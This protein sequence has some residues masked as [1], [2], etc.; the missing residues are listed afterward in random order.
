MTP[1]SVAFLV[2][3]DSFSEAEFKPLR[4]C[5]N[6]VEGMARV[7][8]NPQI[9]SF[10]IVKQKNKRHD[11][12]LEA[13][14]RVTSTLRSGDKLLFYFAGHG[15]RLPQS[16]RLYLVAANTKCEALRSTGIPIDHALDIIRDSR[17]TNRALVLDCCH[18]G[19]VGEAFRGGDVSSGLSDLS[20]SSGT[21]ILTA[22]TAIQLAEERESEGANGTTGNGIFTKYFN[23][24]LE[25]GNIP[26]GEND[27]ITID[28]V[29]DYIH[30]RLSPE[31]SQQPQRF[32]L[33]GAGNFVIGRSSAARWER[34]RSESLRRFHE[35]LDQNIISDEQYVDAARIL[36][37]PWPELTTT[38]KVI[39][40]AALSVLDGKE[41]VTTFCT[42]LGAQATAT[43]RPIVSEPSTARSLR[44]SIV[45]AASSCGANLPYIVALWAHNGF[46]RVAEGLV[47]SSLALLQGAC[48]GAVAGSLLKQFGLVRSLAIPWTPNVVLV[49]VILF[50]LSTLLPPRTG[51][52]LWMVLMAVSAATINA[53]GAATIL[54]ILEPRDRR[55]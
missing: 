33:S 34:R 22:S 12:I 6:D 45:G 18:S 35:L 39:G 36:R 51:F 30:R 41:S 52:E 20:K 25:S 38:Q 17:C 24:A 31:A 55:Q 16:G 7:L 40:E 28:A 5:D 19:A 26:Y 48:Y 13:L 53:I 8:A 9:G 54:L 32:V 46:Q 43:P 44:Y 11:E 50:I 49:I 3:V 10:E 14:E 23:D 29:Y 47:V 42:R 4:F 2:G 37:A 21:Y 1:R 27:E 15:R